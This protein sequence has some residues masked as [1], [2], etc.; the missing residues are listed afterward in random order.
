M[1]DIIII[2]GFT[3][4]FLI[5]IDEGYLLIDTFLPKKYARFLKKL[6]KLSINVSDIKFL[7]LTHHHTDHVGFVKEFREN[8]KIKLIVH[9]KAISYL[10]EGKMEDYTKPLNFIARV[11]KFFTI[12]V[13]G[14][15]YPPIELTSKDI[16]IKEDKSL[17]LKSLM[18]LD[19]IIIRT[20]GSTDDN[21]S[22]VFADGQTITGD[23]LL[24][25]PWPLKF[26]NQPVLITSKDNYIRSWKL[27]KNHN[28]KILHPSHGKKLTIEKLTTNLAKIE[29]KRK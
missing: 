24:N 4:N 28:A 3:K 10:T 2:G 22:I 17:I 19:A 9:E 21:L 15:S 11:V 12:L 25:L 13:L 8:H 23:V 14:D 7:L 26:K 1:V 6:E 27:L 18:G 5:K 29:S 20:P 16:I